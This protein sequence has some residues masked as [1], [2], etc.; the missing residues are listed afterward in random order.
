M[1]RS[2]LAKCAM[3]FFTMTLVVPVLFAAGMKETAPNAV[4]GRIISISSADSVPVIT[5]RTEEGNRVVFSTDKN[6]VSSYPIAS[7]SSGDYIETVAQAEVAQTIRYIN[8]LVAMKI[9]DLSISGSLM[10]VPQTLAE[11]FSYTYGYLLLQSFANQNLFFHGGYYIKG[12]LDGLASATQKVPGSY[13]L[14]EM[15]T[16]IDTYQST[17][18]NAGKAPT[19]FGPAE[20]LDTIN[21]LTVSED[22]TDAFS[23]AYGYL[24]A[25]NMVAQGIELNSDFY[26]AGIMDFAYTNPTLLTDEEMQSAFSEYQAKIEKEYAEWS[27]KAKVEN[28]AKA[29]DYLAQNKSNEGVIT[30]DSGLQYQIQV[31]GTGPKPAATDTVEV[32]Y[33]LQLSD[34]T[35]VESSYDSGTTAHFGVS[36]VIPGFQEALL[37]MNTGSQIRCWIHPTLG[38]GEEGTQKI[39]PNSLLVFDIELVGIDPPATATTTPA[40]A[41]TTPATN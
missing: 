36:Q 6:T 32:N 23:Y 19:D 24:L 3:A 31:A 15:Y 14:D 35:V 8:P 2:K 39:E 18:W 30:T 37:N 28:L 16:N 29:E 13:T 33:Q 5:V 4:T 38:Y 20:S 27:A 22:A 10:E 21:A 17:V 34:G 11:R 40:A 41:V 26:I 25:Y 7:L 9:K 12:S 1:N